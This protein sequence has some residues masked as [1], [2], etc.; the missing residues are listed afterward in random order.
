MF[1]SN[2]TGVP[3]TVICLVR[4]LLL[5]TYLDALDYMIKQIVTS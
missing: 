5:M 4:F 1:L 3:Q 2:A